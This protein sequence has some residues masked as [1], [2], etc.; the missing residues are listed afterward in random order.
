MGVSGRSALDPSGRA[1]RQENGTSRRW[2][3][4]AF[5]SFGLGILSWT[6]SG[7]CHVVLCAIRPVCDLLDDVHEWMGLGPGGV[8]VVLVLIVVGLLASRCCGSC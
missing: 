7:F 1:G 6:S 4:T 2:N 5:V 8:G 3:A